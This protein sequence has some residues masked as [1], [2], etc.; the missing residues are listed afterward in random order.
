M[1]ALACVYTATVPP[2]PAAIEGGCD[3]GNVRVILVKGQSAS[4]L[5]GKREIIKELVLVLALRRLS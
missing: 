1:V 3:Q 4:V 2:H 5:E